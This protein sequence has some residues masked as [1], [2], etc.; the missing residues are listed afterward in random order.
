MRWGGQ[1]TC[2]RHRAGAYR[3]WV[4]RPEGES[5]LGRTK[6]R[7]EENIKT[8]ILEVGWGHALN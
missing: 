3:L 7:W 2:I 1:V 6:S 4:G 5:P 8:N